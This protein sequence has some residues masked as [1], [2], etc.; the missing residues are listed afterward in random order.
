LRLANRGVIALPI[1]D[2]YIV[3][4]R[5]TDKGELM[6]GMAEALHKSV[7]NKVISSRTYPK[8]LPQYG[9]GGGEGGAGVPAPLPLEDVPSRDVVGCIVVFFPESQQRDFFDTTSLAVPASDI[10]GWRGGLAP[11][12]IQKALRHEMHRRGLRHADVAGRIGISRPQFEN[13]LQ[14]RFGASRT[15]ASQIRSFLIEGAKTVGTSS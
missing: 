6:E 14:G 5:V 8:S 2:S 9:D 3:R 12:G 15:I 1:H 7:G 10:L 11:V 4:D 13:I